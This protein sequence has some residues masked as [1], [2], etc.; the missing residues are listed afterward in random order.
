MNIHKYSSCKYETRTTH[1]KKIVYTQHIIIKYLMCV[2]RFVLF[3]YYCQWI[4]IYLFVYLFVFSNRVEKLTFYIF[5]VKIYVSVYH[6]MPIVDHTSTAQSRIASFSLHCILIEMRFILFI[7]WF[8]FI[9]LFYRQNRNK[10]HIIY[11]S[12]ISNTIDR[13]AF[14]LIEPAQVKID[15]SSASMMVMVWVEQFFFLFFCSRFHAYHQYNNINI[16]W[17]LLLLSWWLY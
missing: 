1:K 4:Y 13:F 8:V 10:P 14:R 9:T 17:L 11:V 6:S 15:Y 7:R 16:L 12:N 5:M 3:I 2:M